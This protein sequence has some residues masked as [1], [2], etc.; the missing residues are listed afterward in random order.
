MRYPG[1]ANLLA[2]AVDRLQGADEMRVAQQALSESEAALRRANETLEARVAERSQ[3]FEA[4]QRHREVAE[5][6]LRQSQK[7]DA[8]GQLT[9]GIAHDF[10]NMLTGITG[11][12]DLIRRRLDAGRTHDVA[13]F[14]DAATSSAQ[15]AA[16][17]THR[18]LAF[19]RRQPLDTK[20]TDVNALI[21]GMD[22]LLRRTL[23][24]QTQF[25]IALGEGLWPALTDFNQLENAILNLALNARDAMPEGGR[26]RIETANT[27][28]GA[29]HATADEDITPG[30]YVAVCVS[31]TGM[32]IAPDVLAKVFDPFFTTKPLGQ[33]TGLGLS[34][35]YGFAKQSGAHVRIESKLGQGT[36]V[37]LYL[38]RA[39]AAES[40]VGEARP[41]QTPRG[42][43]EAV[44]VV[45]DDP[46]VRLLMIEVL[47][48][49]GY[50]HHE[51]ADGRE[52]LPILQ[53]G[54]RIDLMVSDVGLPGMNGRKLADLAREILPDLKV[55][56][57]TGY[58]ESAAVRA[59]FLAPGMELLTKPFTLDALG[60]KIRKMI[61]A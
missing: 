2:A 30:P 26:L 14:M 45:E 44:L 11:S 1:Y 33:G 17:L 31:D 34:M 52:A 51:A 32:G 49:L 54:A 53:S 50:A 38:P 40:P 42:R 56:F 6:K 61:E 41:A 16:A 48:E 29:S 59:D 58:A 60:T 46:T 3:A 8:I 39:E 21:V 27:Q 13:R 28:R 18:L 23:G 47:A 19:A 37:K 22:D 25:E 43:G 4:E 20:P 10:N 5:E 12:L 57:V 36:T 9:G 24:E 55:L 15:R 7:M 35:I